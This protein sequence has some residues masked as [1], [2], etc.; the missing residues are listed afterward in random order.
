MIDRSRLPPLGPDAGFRFPPVV[1]TRLANGLRV[2]AVEHRDVPVL[3][4]V[5]VLPAGSATDP[6]GR[7]GLAALTADLIDEGT[8][9]RSAEALHDA[10]AR[11]GAQLDTE[12][13]PDATAVTL[14]TLSRF[15]DPAL[16]LLR[17]VA[18]E[19]ALAPDEF[20]RVR[21]LRCSRLAQL[22]DS[23]GALAER[24][25][26]THLY[27]RHP[28]AHLS[29]GTLA[30]LQSMEPGD[31]HRFHGSH[32]V[33]NEAVLIAVGDL[34]AEALLEAVR[35]AFDWVPPAAR[36]PARPILPP[37]YE[38]RRVVLVDK[39]G[40]PQSELR[41][42]RMGVTRTAPDYHPLVVGNAVL[43][44]Q[45]V[46]RINTNLR[47]QKGL[48]YGARSGFDFR[49]SAGPFIV[50]TSVQTDATVEAALEIVREIA[51]M[52]GPRPITPEELGLARA[53][54]TRGYARSF[55]TAG[56]VARAVAQLEIYELA[57]SWFDDF[58]RQVRLVEAEAVTSA[59]ARRLPTSDLLT[60]VVGDR[61]QVEPGLR[62]SGLGPLVLEP[63]VV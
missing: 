63:A 55:E 62:E 48:T 60:V 51:E 31:V 29:V 37:D 47:E 4:L 6:E 13:G 59:M 56:Q 50:Q 20:A 10:L 49:R 38:G 8:R 46:S 61:E 17:E 1:R 33:P 30:S 24:A 16:A 32:Y 57:D 22:K 21:D 11:L 9:T 45:F 44:G 34:R 42:G 18:F 28:Y 12:P 5:L 54:L 58:V 43:G 7:E 41:I 40:A 2:C 14:T 36:P 27:G 15:T 25:F 35:R 53:S 23:A 26:S 39:P 19:P 3:S 52:Q